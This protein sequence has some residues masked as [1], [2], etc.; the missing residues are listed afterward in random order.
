VTN[1]H[2]EDTDQTPVKEKEM[3]DKDAEECETCFGDEEVDCEV[4]DGTGAIDERECD[5]CQ[6]IGQ[7]ECPECC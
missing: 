4:C 1:R 2:R 6:G 3:P 7:I 5:E